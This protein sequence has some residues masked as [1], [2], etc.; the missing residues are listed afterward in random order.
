MLTDVTV[1]KRSRRIIRFLPVPEALD[2]LGPEPLPPPEGKEVGPKCVG[3]ERR[4]GGG[5]PRGVQG[6]GRGGGRGAA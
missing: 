2:P 6:P 5:G 3:C 1:E 4:R